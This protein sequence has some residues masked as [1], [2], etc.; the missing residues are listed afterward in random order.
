MEYT[1]ITPEYYET[2]ETNNTVYY[3]ETKLFFNKKMRKVLKKEFRLVECGKNFTIPITTY[4]YFHLLNYAKLHNDLTEF[5]HYYE[6]LVRKKPE[7][8]DSGKNITLK[9]V[10]RK[11]LFKF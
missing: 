10:K 11:K 5:I 1:V 3:C 8:L 2:Y 4:F 6:K 9:G 7:F